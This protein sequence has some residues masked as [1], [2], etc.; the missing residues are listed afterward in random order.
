MRIRPP[1]VSLVSRRFFGLQLLGLV[2]L[3]QLFPVF[4]DESRI[5]SNFVPLGWGDVAYDVFFLEHVS[6]IRSIFEAVEEGG[7]RGLQT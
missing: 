4:S 7:I 1:L 3:L 5:R 6:K 2:V